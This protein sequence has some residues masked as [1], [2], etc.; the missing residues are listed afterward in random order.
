MPD[1]L[2]LALTH[3]CRMLEGEAAVQ[4]RTVAKAVGLSLGHFQR[5]FRARVGVTPQQYRRRVRAERARSKLTLAPRVTD[6]VYDAGY[7]S[8]SRF[9]ADAGKE[10]GMPPA[11]WADGG[12]GE[13]IRYAARRCSVG[14][15]LVAW[16]ARGVCSVSLG[17]DRRALVAVLSE[18]L[19]AA[20]LRV[21]KD[22]P[23]LD[24]VVAEVDGGVPPAREVPL[25]IRVTAFQARVFEAL[26]A[27]PTG[28]T[29]S[30]AEVAR[31]LGAPR[32]ARAVAAACAS[33]PIAILVPCHRVI[34]A[35]GHHGGYRWGS[36]RKT[37]LLDQ[38]RART[39]AA[40]QPRD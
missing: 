37:A 29:R 15:V 36:A 20:R 25:D 22:A 8:S 24:A 3:A 4:T 11:A 26:R 28:Q 23:W 7:A 32:A 40:D 16:T 18:A 38:E 2:A 19:P 6:A 5:V 27:I 10:L 33:N 30:Y 14:Q 12:R 9:Y 31:T 1:P 17:E 34:R 39:S 35:D 21:C 13:D